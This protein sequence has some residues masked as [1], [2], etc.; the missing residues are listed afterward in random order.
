MDTKETLAFNK[1]YKVG[2]RVR[3]KWSRDFES[4]AEIM[5]P[6]Q[7]GIVGVAQIE[8]FVRGGKLSTTFVD[9]GDVLAKWG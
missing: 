4:E 5:T 6:A 1:K 2:D 3:V 7:S 9:V 8:P